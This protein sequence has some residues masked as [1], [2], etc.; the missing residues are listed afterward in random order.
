MHWQ[1]GGHKVMCSRRRTSSWRSH[2][3]WCSVWAAVPAPRTSA[4]STCRT[5]CE[6]D[7]AAQGT[8]TRK[9]VELPGSGHRQDPPAWGGGCASFEMAPTRQLMVRVLKWIR[10]AFATLE[11][12]PGSAMVEAVAKV[13]ARSRV[14]YKTLVRFPLMNDLRAWCLISAWFGHHCHNVVM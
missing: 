7:D 8:Y 5:P 11:H 3:R 2:A 6:P 13:C 9:R 14:W 4:A 10:W 1:A 12:Q